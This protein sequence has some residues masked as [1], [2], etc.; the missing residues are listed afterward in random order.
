[1][2]VRDKDRSAFKD[3]LDEARVIVDSA[4]ADDRDLTPDE[5]SEVDGLIA[6]AE[7]AK[8]RI[9]SDTKDDTLAVRIAALMGDP[10]SDEV[11][12]LAPKTLGEAFADHPLFK[13][14]LAANTVDGDVP[15]SLKNF[16]TPSVPIPSKFL[17]V[18]DLGGTD[19]AF[20][21]VDY[22]GLLVPEKFPSGYERLIGLLT[23]GTT[24]SSLIH[25][26]EETWTYAAEFVAEATASSGTSGTKPESSAVYTPKTVP[27]STIAHWVAATKWALSD[28]GQLR[29]LIDGGLRRG[30]IKKLGDAILNGDGVAP[31]WFGFMNLASIPTVGTTG[32]PTLPLIRDALGA[33]E[34]DGYMA[35]GIVLNRADWEAIKAANPA[36]LGDPFNMRPPNIDGVPVIVL[37]QM[38]A[39]VGLVG[40]F[41]TAF[42]LDREQSTITAT[43]SHA[44]F[45]IRNLVA[46]LGEWRGAFF[47]PAP[48]A[49]RTVAEGA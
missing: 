46:I 13:A 37:P 22:R 36:P 6:K 12:D 49:F 20:P 2:A 21:S 38:A 18:A 24:G 1:M 29:A 19:D 14:W 16:R 23:R 3:A 44:D 28:V 42:L 5:K 7:D 26:A 9:E 43:D 15:E 30:I 45:F 33:I 32:A 27:V 48:K 34:D 40:E 41:A 8:S 25:Y 17:S 39:G 31:E 4:K 11:D 47:V 10:K 35:D